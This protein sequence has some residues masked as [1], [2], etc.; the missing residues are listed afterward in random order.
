MSGG[1]GASGLLID[2][3]KAGEEQEQQQEEELRWPDKSEAG[4]EEKRPGCLT[5]KQI[6][7]LLPHALSAYLCPVR[8][9]A[10]DLGP[11]PKRHGYTNKR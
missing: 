3:W 5:V 9:S 4:Q 2:R 11:G 7:M 1:G 6:K 8:A 10:A